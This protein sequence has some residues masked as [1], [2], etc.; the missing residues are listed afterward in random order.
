[1]LPKNV[2]YYGKD[3]SPPERRE[4]RAGPL[5]LVYEGGDLR[6][7]KLGDREIL[8]R[9]YVAVRDRN[10]NTILPALSNVRMD[11]YDDSFHIE[12]EAENKQSDIDFFWKGKI[13]GDRRGRIAFTMD[14]VARST[15]LRNRIGICV[16]HPIRECAGQ[17]CV[18]E[19]VDGTIERGAFPYYIS[20][21]QP[22]MEMRAISHEVVPGLS[23]EVRFEGEVFEMEDQRNWTDAS[24]KTYSTPLALP[25]PVEVKEGTTISQS[26]TLTLKGGIPEEAPRIRVGSPEVIFTVGERPSVHL[27]RIGLGMA[28]HGQ[29]LS[30]N[31]RR[32]L[33]ALNLAHLRVDLKLSDPNYGEI[34]SRAAS[35]ADVLGVSLEVAIFLTDSAEEEIRSLVEDLRK[36]GPR[37]SAWLIFHVAE[38]ST[39]EQWIR[40]AR[41]YLSSCDPKAKIGAGTNFYFTELNRC[42]P[43]IDALDLVCYS[44]NPQVHA[45][46]NASLVESLETQAWTVASARRFIGDLPLAVTPVTLKPRFN[47]SATGPERERGA[48]DL[49]PQVD[50]RQMSLFGAG[51]TLGS[52]KYLS[53]SG[54]HSI[55]YYET[56]GWRGVMETERGSPLPEK[57]LSIPGGVFPLYHV[58]ADVG[59]FAGGDVIP[60]TSSVPLKVDGMTIQKE[61]LT[62]ILLANLGPEEKRV[63]LIYDGLSEYA[64]VKHLDETNAERAMRSP[65]SFGAELGPLQRTSGNHFEISLSPY[66]IARIDFIANCLAAKGGIDG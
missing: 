48:G 41:R 33:K 37:I 8:R 53:E 54:V 49:P 29:P 13:T 23:A 66:A 12:Y 42:R 34:L 2:L 57:F 43:P 10:W 28:S 38:K 59:E 62:R 7:I 14:G 45:F 27:P 51:W 44:I 52:L 15:F 46:D 19:K 39:A 61:G 36:L 4:L 50:A 24:F 25:F 58:L 40:L 3:E 56:T 47:P 21:H 31:E 20:P 55:T 22:F 11:I 5:S 17:P 64:R 9:I 30:D 16:L 63:R 26:I 1:M 18:V 32:R 65:E 60:S 6:Y 35:E